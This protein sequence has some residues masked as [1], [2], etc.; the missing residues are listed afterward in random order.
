MTA[1]VSKL[2]PY[3]T[4]APVSALKALYVK[5]I[6]GKQVSIYYSQTQTIF[7]TTLAIIAFTQSARLRG[8]FGGQYENAAILS[9]IF[10]TGSV[11]QTFLAKTLVSSFE[12]GVSAVKGGNTIALAKNVAF[13]LLACAASSEETR[14]LYLNWVVTPIHNYFFSESC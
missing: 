5:K 6:S 14:T 8:V 2:V 12:G 4:P 11:A 3:F 10:F 9:T 13:A 1:L 7:S